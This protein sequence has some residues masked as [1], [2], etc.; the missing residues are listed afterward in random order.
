[1]RGMG[2]ENGDSLLGLLGLLSS[3]LWFLCLHVKYTHSLLLAL[4]TAHCTCYLDIYLYRV[5]EYL[6]LLS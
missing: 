1:M 4:H 5:L 6:D 3:D 2:K